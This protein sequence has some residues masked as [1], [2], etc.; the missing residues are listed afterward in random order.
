MKNTM[1]QASLLIFLKFMCMCLCGCLPCVWVSLKAREAPE[2]E[3]T[4]RYE[5]SNMGAKN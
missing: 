5:P 1:Q 2:A 4:G 3:V